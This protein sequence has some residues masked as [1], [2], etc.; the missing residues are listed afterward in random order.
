MI[1]FSND[2]IH[3]RTLKHRFDSIDEVRAATTKALNSIPETDFHRA[4]DEWQ[5]RR[6]KSMDAGGMFVEDY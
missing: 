6:T 1:H 5:T 4:F 3:L 2:I